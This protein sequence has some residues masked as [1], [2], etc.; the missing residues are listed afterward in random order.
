M[1]GQVGAEQCDSRLGSDLG[2]LGEPLRSSSE[3]ITSV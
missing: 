3:S 1:G 2:E